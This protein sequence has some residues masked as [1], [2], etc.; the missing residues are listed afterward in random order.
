M[1][2]AQ[3]AIFAALEA[4]I[5]HR[6]TNR[7]VLKIALTHASAAEGRKDEPNY[8]RL[9]FFGDRILGLVVAEYLFG[10]YPTE[11]EH[12]LAPRLNALVNK[13]TCARAAVRAELGPAI[14][15]SKAEEQAGGREKETILGDV[16]EAM[17]AALYLDAG[18]PAARAFIEKYWAE[19]FASVTVAPR[20][21]KTALQEWA[22]A[23]RRGVPRYRVVSRDGPD[24]A[25]EFTV[26]VD[27]K[28]V[29]PVQGQAGSKRDA[30]REAARALLKMVGVDV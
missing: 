6:F 13:Q 21:P 8:E 11:A 27:V 3:E 20:D 4:R 30:E 26:E 16:A 17:I 18:M 29:D 9:E 12:G 10:A 19:E 24:H 1:S 2:R 14:I 22:A 25:P 28:G 5:G 15:L 7:Q 23:A